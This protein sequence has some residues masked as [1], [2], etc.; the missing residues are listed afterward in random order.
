MVVNGIGL[1]SIP[2]TSPTQ[3]LGRFFELFLTRKMLPSEIK[4]FLR[5]LKENKVYTD[6]GE[7]QNGRAF[8]SNLNSKWLEHL[9]THHSK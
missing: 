7:T 8:W 4:T 2:S 6:Y 3:K 5:F 1:G 9:S